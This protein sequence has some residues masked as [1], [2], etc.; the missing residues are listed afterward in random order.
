MTV[1][2]GNRR[3]SLSNLEKELYPNGFTK[4]QVITYYSRIAPVLVSH[5]AGRP[6]TVIRYPDGVGGEQFFEKN[7]ARGAPAWL[8]RVRLP[9][10]GSRGSGDTITS[11]L[12]DD[13]PALVW[14]ANLAALEL[15]GT[16]VDCQPGRHA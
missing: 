10:S 13:L 5:L 16:T 8:H 7:V 14:A 11:L 2:V 12:I 6:L 15:A 9:S 3:L 1:Q 4:A